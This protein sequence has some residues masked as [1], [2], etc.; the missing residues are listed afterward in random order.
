VLLQGTKE[1]FRR[2]VL[3]QTSCDDELGSDAMIASAV[4][5]ANLKGKS[6]ASLDGCSVCRSVDPVFDSV[7]CFLTQLLNSPWD[8]AIDEARNIGYVALAGQHQL[9]KYDISANTI[10]QFSGDGYERN[11][12]GPR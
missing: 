6:F 7:H 8:V 12:N 10:G 1:S 4:K 11:L 5:V 2:Q 9:W 3:P